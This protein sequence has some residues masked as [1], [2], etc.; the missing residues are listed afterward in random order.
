VYDNNDTLWE[1]GSYLNQYDA[2][3]FVMTK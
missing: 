2:V 3:A 1:D